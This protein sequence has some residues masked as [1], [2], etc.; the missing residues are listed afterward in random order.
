MKDFFQ[1]KILPLITK[2][3]DH[4][5]VKAIQSGMMATVGIS[6]VGGLL[7]L[8]MSPP[9]TADTTNAF[10]LAW[11]AFAVANTWWITVGYNLTINAV[12]IWVVIGLTSA[13]ATKKKM[14]PTGC[15]VTSLI[16]F[17][18]FCGN[19]SAE[20]GTISMAWLG[21]KGL[22]TGMLLS[23]INVQ[24]THFLKEHGVKI[25]LPDS[26]PPNVS[27]PLENLIV[28]AMVI[29]LA[30][31]G[32]MLLV[33]NGL[34]LPAMIQN[35]F[36][37]LVSSSDSLLAVMGAMLL[38][39]VLWFFGLHGTSIVNAVLTPFLLSNAMANLEAYQAGAPIPFINSSGFFVFQIGMLPLAIAM[40]LFAKSA[41]LKTV[42]KIGLVPSI[43]NI[44]EPITFGTPTVLNFKMMI[45]TIF[46]FVLNFAVAYLIMSAGIVGKPIFQVPFTV[47]GF[48]GAFITTLDVKAI[49]LWVFLVVIDVLFYLPFLKSYDR[50][51]VKQETEAE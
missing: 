25:K 2:F 29:V 9:V 23:I 7:L 8:L 28:D 16:I 3:G 5:M 51:L 34:S 43:F 30:V 14:Q 15:I 22:F 32:N 21:A 10:M 49:F 46:T 17:F 48:I 11:K 47:P 35:L 26:V 4:Y 12:G 36:A 27:A 13:L 1:D 41:Q 31:V 24:L 6:T 33:S 39:R 37:P 45:P 50:D 19:Y 42:G 38:M 44:G 40:L 20:T 18:V